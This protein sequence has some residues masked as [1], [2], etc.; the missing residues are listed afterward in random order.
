MNIIKTIKAIS[1]KRKLARRIDEA[2]SLRE[3][4]GRKRLILVVKRQPLI[5]T[6]KALQILIN[7]GYF[8]K[9]TKM[10]DLEKKALFLTK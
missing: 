7:K 2:V 9:G 5:F 10:E 4:D 3:K 8:K 1:F 6:K